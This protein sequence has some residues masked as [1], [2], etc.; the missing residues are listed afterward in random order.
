MHSAVPVSL[1]KCSR[2]QGS[3]PVVCDAAVHAKP[4]QGNFR[5]AIAGQAAGPACLAIS[6]HRQTKPQPCA[7][8]YLS[9][10]EVVD[11]MMVSRS[12]MKAN[13]GWGCGWAG[14]TIP[15]LKTSCSWSNRYLLICMTDGVQAAA[16]HTD[17]PGGDDGDCT[18]CFDTWLLIAGSG[19]CNLYFGCSSNQTAIAMHIYLKACV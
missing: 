16:D 17:M 6:P 4:A 9:A 11:C 10:L 5:V 1:V 12:Y 13:A 18:G 15:S 3:T 8:S 7:P 2:I 19:T 14:A